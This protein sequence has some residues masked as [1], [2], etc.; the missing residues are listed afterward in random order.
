MMRGEQEQGQRHTGE[1]DWD[2]RL[3]LC[4]PRVLRNARVRSRRTADSEMPPH[5]DRI[6]SQRPTSRSFRAGTV[7]IAW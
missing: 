7:D 1:E 5:D 2:E 3:G 4:R 6:S